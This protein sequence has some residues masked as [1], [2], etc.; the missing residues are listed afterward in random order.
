M[1]LCGSPNQKR[2]CKNWFWSRSLAENRSSAV[3][4]PTEAKTPNLQFLSSQKAKDAKYGKLPFGQFC[5]AGFTPSGGP[6]ILSCM[7]SAEL[8]HFTVIEARPAQSLH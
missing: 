4:G 7:S 6:V 8:S 3:S 2:G 5:L 1:R